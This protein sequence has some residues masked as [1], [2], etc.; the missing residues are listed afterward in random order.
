LQPTVEW[1]NCAGANDHWLWHSPQRGDS[2]LEWTSSCRWQLMQKLPLPASGRL[3][4][5]HR[6]HG[7]LSCMPLR[8]KSPTSCCGRMSLKLRIV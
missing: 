4:W 8:E 7:R 2:E 5:W 1:S 3:S 6:L